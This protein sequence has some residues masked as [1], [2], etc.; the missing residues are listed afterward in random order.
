MYS[1]YAGDVCIYNDRFVLP[2]MAVTN[3]KLALEDNSAGFLAIT[4]PVTNLGYSIIELLITDITVLKEDKWLWSGRVLSEARDFNNN[5]VLTCEGALAFLNDSTQPPGEHKGSVRDYIVELINVHNSKVAPNRQ[6]AIGDITVRETDP[7]AVYYTNYEKTIE[8]IKKNLLD[9]L[10]GHIRVR[11]GTDG[12][13]YLDYLADYP[14]TS[15]QTIEFGK[16]LIDFTRRWDE[17]EYATVIIPLGARLEGKDRAAKKDIPEALDA[18]LTVESENGGKLYVKSDEAEQNFGWI[19]KVVT[20]D[21]VTTAKALLEKAQQ[22][23]ADLQFSDVEIELSALDLHYLHVEIAAVE[24]LDQIQVISRP[25]GMNRVFPVTKIEIPL[26]KPADTVFSLGM[27]EKV[28]M[29]SSSNKATSQLLQKI[30]NLPKAHSLLKEAQITATSIMNMATTGYVTIIKNEDGSEALYISNIKDYRDATQLWKWSLS[31]LGYWTNARE[32]NAANRTKRFGELTDPFFGMAMTMDGAIVADFITAGTMSADRVRTGILQSEDKHVVFDLTNG[33][34]TMKSGSIHIGT[35][36]A[37]ET[38][39]EVDEQGNLTAR[40]G[41]FQGHVVA[42]SGSFYGSV[43]ATEFLLSNGTSLVSLIDEAGK[44]RGEWLNLMGLTITN[45]AGDAVMTISE[46]GIKFGSQYKP[47]KVRYST[48]KNARIPSGFSETWNSSWNGT[49][50]EVW[51]IYSYDGGVTWTQTPSLIQGKTGA[52]GP[53]GSD[54]NVPAWVEAYTRTAT[55]I[56]NQWVIAPN[57]CGG[58]I[59]ALDRMEASCDF[60]VGN[61]IQLGEATDSGKEIIFSTAAGISNP[62]NTDNLCLSA[63]GDIILSTSMRL[64]LS[65]VGDII[66][67][68][69]A[70]K[71]VFG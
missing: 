7:E 19:E 45:K 23:L 57:I 43:Q 30:E 13:L 44:I 31:G 33:K 25:H 46:D 34:L 28:S 51:A 42:T 35:T 22:Y 65:G 3:P 71:A 68:S 53:A 32:P 61:K 16:N 60:Y 39:F 69:N 64:D 63:F 54:A 18:Y 62:L 56:D 14:K 40:R 15:T 8:C 6:F 27:S 2:N 20:F 52:R 70:P 9:R 29:T 24:L 48:N 66:W 10:G 36:E 12:R 37:G 21:D 47:I 38:A 5:R 4:L 11:K 58:T 41:T 49:S 50:T 55:Y 26:D 17:S 67:G 59:T 1:I